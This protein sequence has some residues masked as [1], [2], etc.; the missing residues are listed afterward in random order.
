MFKKQIG[1]FALLF[2]HNVSKFE[3]QVLSTIL[4]FNL[5][6]LH[7]DVVAMFKNLK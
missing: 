1:H 5:S 6:F 7:F 2:C 3:M 4:F